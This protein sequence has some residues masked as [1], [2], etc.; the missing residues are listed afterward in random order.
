MRACSANGRGRKWP[1]LQVIAR[2]AAPFGPTTGAGPAATAAAELDDFVQLVQTARGLL[3]TAIAN[4]GPVERAVDDYRWKCFE[5]ERRRER[6]AQAQE[7][8]SLERE[9]A[10]LHDHIRELLERG[11]DTVRAR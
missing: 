8:E 10:A 4:Y 5:V 9:V 2:N 11:P 6:G 1:N 3:S 7:L